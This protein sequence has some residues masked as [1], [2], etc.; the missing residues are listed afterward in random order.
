[1]NGLGTGRPPTISRGHWIDRSIYRFSKSSIL[2]SNINKEDYKNEK[3]RN[4]ELRCRKG[5]I[6]RHWG[7]PPLAESRFE[8]VSHVPF[9]VG[10]AAFIVE[11]YYCYIAIIDLYFKI[12]RSIQGICLSRLALQLQK[13]TVLP[14]PCGVMIRTYGGI[15][16]Q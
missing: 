12:D 9:G 13:Q 7:Q 5:C 4:K 14:S 1:M 11:Y 8:H 15:L 2:P 10:T 16:V 3:T 6:D